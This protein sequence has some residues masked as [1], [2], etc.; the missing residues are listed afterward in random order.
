MTG[1]GLQGKNIP[2]I[3]QEFN[4]KRVPESVRV[5]ITKAG[6]IPQASL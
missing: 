5:N 2:T 3:T 4:T 6:F 1:K